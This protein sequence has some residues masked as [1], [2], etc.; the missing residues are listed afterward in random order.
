[1]ERLGANYQKTGPGIL[2]KVPDED[3]AELKKI[4]D[5]TGGTARYDKI[6]ELSRKKAEEMGMQFD[7]TLNNEYFRHIY[8]VNSKKHT[9]EE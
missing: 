5:V 2:R 4:F 7:D 9:E 1:M 8:T 3:L 6:E